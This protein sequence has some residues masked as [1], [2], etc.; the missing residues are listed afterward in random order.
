[1][2]KINY[3]VKLNEALELYYAKYKKIPPS[4]NILYNRYLSMSR[5]LSC[6]GL[7]N[8]LCICSIGI[9]EI[10][11]ISSYM[12]FIDEMLPD[13]FFEETRNLLFPEINIGDM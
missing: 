4:V 1:M 13:L 2:T 5:V 10:K 7:P 6:G 8:G 9:V 12:D 11:P 3:Y